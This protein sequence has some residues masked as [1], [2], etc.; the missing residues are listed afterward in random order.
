[1]GLTAVL[2][3]SV[4]A[5]VAPAARGPEPARGAAE[6]SGLL[7]RMAAAYA[8]V[9]QYQTETQ[10]ETYR[11]GKVAETR[12]F[13]YTFRKPN[14]IR[15]DLESPN[16]GTTLVYPDKDGRVLVKPGGLLGF[17]KLHLSPDSPRLRTPSGQRIDQ[18]DLGLLIENIAHSVGDRRRGPPEVVDR[19]GRTVIEVLADDHF[20][21]GVVTLYRFTVDGASWLP[22]EV[23]EST[24]EGLLKRHIC[25]RDL[26]TSVSVPDDYFRTGDKGREDGRAHD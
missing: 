23:H 7:G 24:P 10:V 19:D 25:F 4:I 15:V 5:A 1:M 9:E 17:L 20:L 16:R 26:E 8:R 6:V 2:L 13:L 12:R 11:D 14:H 22:V 3:S 18:S 21:P